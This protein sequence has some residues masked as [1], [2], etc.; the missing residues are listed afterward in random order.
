[1]TATLLSPSD[2]QFEFPSADPGWYTA[3]ERP[4]SFKKRIIRQVENAVDAHVAHMKN[5]FEERG[6]QP[7]TEVRKPEHFEWLALRQ[8]KSLTYASIAGLRFRG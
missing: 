8:V 2:R 1:M 5:L 3:L 4:T 6:G 7:L